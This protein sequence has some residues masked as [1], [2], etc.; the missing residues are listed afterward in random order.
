MYGLLIR[1]ELPA[2]LPVIAVRI[3]PGKVS[4]MKGVNLRKKMYAAKLEKEIQLVPLRRPHSS[5]GM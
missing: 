1:N 2:Y 5:Y 4:L 3:V